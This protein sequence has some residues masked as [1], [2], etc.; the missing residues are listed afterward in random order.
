[1]T[2]SIQ[3][4]EKPLDERARGVLVNQQQK[5]CQSC[6]QFRNISAFFKDTGLCFTC[7]R[8]PKVVEQQAQRGSA[9]RHMKLGQLLG[10]SLSR[11]ELTR[12]WANTTEKLLSHITEEKLEKA[13]V[14]VLVLAACQAQDKTLLLEGRPTAI[15]GYA[16]RGTM[17]ERLE[18]INEELRRRGRLKDVTPARELDAAA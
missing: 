2:N 11:K 1:M 10:K 5:L 6:G 14:G 9:D 16:E 4:D 8:D 13:P 15:V 7:G 18:R 3:T 17:E 12:V